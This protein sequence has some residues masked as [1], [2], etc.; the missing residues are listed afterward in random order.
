MNIDLYCIDKSFSCKYDYWHKMRNEIIKATFDYIYIEFGIIEVNYNSSG[1]KYKEILQ[2]IIDDVEQVYDKNLYLKHF[3]EKCNSIQNIDSMI[4]FGIEGLEALCNK[5]A[6]EGL[7]SAGDSY[8]ICELFKLVK[9]FLFKNMENINSNENDIYH[10]VI[11]LE[12]VFQESFEK[13]TM[14]TIC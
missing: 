10:S 3:V 11:E 2:K 5:R 7:Y 12:K 6:I 13:N 14:I 9:P 4:F 8:S 1:Y